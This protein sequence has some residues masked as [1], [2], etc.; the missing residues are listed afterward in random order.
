MIQSEDK[1]LSG[2]HHVRVR[3]VCEAHG[4]AVREVRQRGVLLELVPVSLERLP[5]AGVLR[6]LADALAGDGVRYV[7]L[8]LEEEEG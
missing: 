7:A 6:E 3:E 8:S 4:L 5:S 2:A 1:G